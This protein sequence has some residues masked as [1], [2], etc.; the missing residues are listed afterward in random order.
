MAQGRHVELIKGAASLHASAGHEHVEPAVVDEDPV[1]EVRDGAIVG[2][3]TAAALHSAPGL[4]RHAS[5]GALAAS[6]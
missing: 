6:G 4:G 3:V 2:D 1:D 5:S